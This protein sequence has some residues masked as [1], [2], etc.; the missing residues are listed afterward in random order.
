MDQ[1][2]ISLKRDIAETRSAMEEKIEMIANR[3]HNTIVGPKIAIDNLIE[4]L[5]QARQAMQG[6]TSAVDNGANPIQRAIAESTERVKATINLI[7]QVKHDPWI[8]LGSAVLIGYVIGS[9]PRLSPFIRRVPFPSSIAITKDAAT[10]A[11]VLTKNS[12]DKGVSKEDC[13]TQE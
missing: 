2:E 4:N 5:D 6:T 1:T 9:L 11:L 7:D 13:A 10:S 8:M 12:P 3:I